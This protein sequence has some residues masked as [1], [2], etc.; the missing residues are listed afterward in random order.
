MEER[1]VLGT[2][3]M[4]PE[5]VTGWVPEVNHGR[6]PEQ[7]A[8]QKVE[9]WLSWKLRSYGISQATGL[10]SSNSYRPQTKLRKGNVFAPV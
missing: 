7:P 1:P 8:K 2:A 4:K 10:H 9:I 6:M 5:G 3:T